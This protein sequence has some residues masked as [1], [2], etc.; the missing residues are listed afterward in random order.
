MK[1][2]LQALF[3]LL[4]FFAVLLASCNDKDIFEKPGGG[5]PQH[6][7][8]NKVVFTLDALPGETGIVT[9]LSAL[10]TIENAQNETIIPSQKLALRFEGMYVS[11]TLTLVSGDYKVTRFMIVDAA[12]KT[13]FV[14]PVANSEMSG[15]V[16]KPLALYFKLP[17][18]TVSRLYMDLLRIGAGAQPE[19]Y[20][21]PAGAFNLPP[22]EEP[23]TDP[24]P[25]IKIK[26]RPLI[27]IG[28]VVYDSVP[29]AFTLTSWN[30]AG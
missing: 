5:K 19:K 27:K 20:G 25:F 11:D 18:T 10:V 22:S 30:A 7:V 24:N 1:P 9:N 17:Q 28:E 21:Y 15:Q 6:M 12:N 14:T 26:V 4:L 29:V 23:Q 13:R 2:K 16:Q 3:N 8:N